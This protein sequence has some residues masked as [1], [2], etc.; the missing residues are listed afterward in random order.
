MSER[1]K[2]KGPPSLWDMDEPDGFVLTEPEPVEIAS[3]YSISIEYDKRGKPLI[4][5]KRY[6]N[7]KAKGLRR[8]IERS[9]PGATILGLDKPILVEKADGQSGHKKR[10]AKISGKNSD[11]KSRENHHNHC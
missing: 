1:K 8:E 5:V 6:G 7:V 3:G 2:R 9:Y 4:R 10:L 11:K